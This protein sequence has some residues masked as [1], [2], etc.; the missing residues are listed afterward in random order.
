MWGRWGEH[1]RVRDMFVRLEI[2]HV[3]YASS[4]TEEEHRLRVMNHEVEWTGGKERHIESRSTQ[5][6]AYSTGPM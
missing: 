3:A 2:I 4:M 6:E 1:V 5:R